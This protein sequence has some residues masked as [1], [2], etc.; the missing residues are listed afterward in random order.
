MLKKRHLL[1]FFA[2]LSNVLIGNAVASESSLS[3][4]DATVPMTPP[5]IKSAQLHL[6]IVNSGSEVRELVG[7]A[8][9]IAEA[10]E[11]HEMKMN[12]GK[13]LMRKIDGL[14][15][16]AEGETVLEHGSGYH[17]MLIGLTSSLEVGK[18]VN[19]TLTFKNGE[20]LQFDAT[21]V[22]PHSHHHH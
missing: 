2:L 18:T 9:D 3:V 22:E 11:I 4:K 12:D 20:T 7:V 21:V 6:T 5:G 10:M 8:S 15:V 19:F 13:M 1:I 14:D 16:P 17:L